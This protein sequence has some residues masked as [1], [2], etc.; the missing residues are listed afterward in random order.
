MAERG[1]GHLVFISSL[2]GKTA[3]PGSSIYSATK[4]GLRG[5]GRGAARRP[6]AARASA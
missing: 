4:F 2:A 3:T 1:A 6:R 5:F